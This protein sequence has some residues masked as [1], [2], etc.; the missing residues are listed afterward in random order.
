VSFSEERRNHREGDTLKTPSAGR[1]IKGKK[2]RWRGG[3]QKSLGDSPCRREK[4]GG[5]GDSSFMERQWA[6]THAVVRLGSL[7]NKKWRASQNRK[8]GGLWSRPGEDGRR[9]GVGQVSEGTGGPSQYSLKRSEASGT[10]F[11]G[12]GKK[13]KEGGVWNSEKGKSH[14]TWGKKDALG[15]GENHHSAAS[16]KTKPKFFHIHGKRN[17]SKISTSEREGKK[18]RG[19]REVSQ[20]GKKA[21]P[22]AD[23]ANLRR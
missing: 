11:V 20:M 9:R 12:G 19:L 14:Q 6:E 1:Q 7:K 8:G 18:N 16:N 10:A 4:E 21:T 15:K 2:Y 22:A 3:G 17:W 5:G 23:R 13:R